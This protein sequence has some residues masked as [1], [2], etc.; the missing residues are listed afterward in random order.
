MKCR[1]AFVFIFLGI[2]LSLNNDINAYD[3]TDLIDSDS[4]CVVSESNTNQCL[5]ESNDYNQAMQYGQQ[6][7]DN[8]WFIV[9]NNKVVSANHAIALLDQTDCLTNVEYIQE[10]NDA[11]GY[12]NGCYGVDSA[13]IRT[14]S[15]ASHALIRLSGVDAWVP[16]N[17]VTIVPLALYNG[18]LSVYY[19]EDG[20]L[21]HAILSDQRNY[22]S[23]NEYKLDVAPDFFSEG[24]DY[25]SYDGHYFYDDIT[26]CLNDIANNT[27]SNSVNFNQPYY[28]FYQ[29]NNHLT[30]SNVSNDQLSAILQKL[31]SDEAF[32][33]FSD[34]NGDS[35]ADNIYGSLLGN[36]SN[37]FINAQDLNNVNALMM[38]ALS[39]NESGYGRS[40]LAYTRNNLFGHAAYD[41]AV[42]AN[43]SRYLS[44]YSSIA[45][46]AKNYI[47]DSYCDASS[48]TYHG[49]YFGNKNSG[50]NV[51]YA[52]D[53]YWGEKAASYYYQLDKQLNHNDKNSH[54][55]IVSTN[56]IWV[57]KDATYNNH[58]TQYKGNEHVFE[59]VSLL[60]NGYKVKLDHS[61]EIDGLV[62]NEGFITKED[63]AYIYQ[64]PNEIEAP[65]AITIDANGGSYQNG[66]KTL[67]YFS[68]NQP[69]LIP[70]YPGHQFIAYQQNEQGVYVAQY[71]ETLQLKM[72]HLPKLLY[73]LNETID[74]QDGLVELTYADGTKESVP[75]SIE[76]LSN[77]STK[78]SG[79]QSVT[80]SY[81]GQQCT[82][83]I[84]VSS[85]KD[86]QYQSIKETLN[87]TLEYG[88]AT[89]QQLL[90]FKSLFDQ[91]T[92]S[93]PRFSM[94]EYAALSAIFDPVLALNDITI[95]FSGEDLVSV[96][97]LGLA[98][99]LNHYSDNALF[100]NHFQINLTQAKAQLA[101]DNPFAQLGYALVKSYDLIISHNWESVK[102]LATPI[103]IQL[104]LENLNNHRYIVY[105]DDGESLVQ[106][107]TY[108]SASG[109]SFISNMIGKI[110][111]V[112]TNN[113]T[114]IDELDV[115]GYFTKDNQVND[116]FN[117]TDLILH[118]LIALITI[119][120]VLLW[121][122]LVM[123]IIKKGRKRAY[124]KNKTRTARVSR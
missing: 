71:K 57:Y 78:E 69:S 67:T 61:V 14:N 4:Y 22:L 50:M 9:K 18:N 79:T 103:L 12:T 68:Y 37:D 72:A 111:I 62:Y 41:H 115:S 27:S 25:Y 45:S 105:C 90:E 89:T 82:Y 24:N 65:Q 28:N 80:V 96:G 21:V 97:N 19:V 93:F 88:S 15:N 58:L 8:A 39:L 53:P 81:G 77:V 47:V 34:L 29:Y 91:R 30:L 42:E 113:E 87:A 33:Y 76:M 95:G 110:Y 66:E 56:D 100:A 107:P 46:H 55:F 5:F 20:E 108:Q 92:S 119:A 99:N 86:E 60:D 83:L 2:I 6:L 75:L 1:W 10:S 101:Q 23:R 106:L 70:Y 112:D 32:T 64:G 114:I 17:Q 16:I 7:S 51:S 63:V 102:S 85:Q 74:T 123:V 35:V 122:G 52:S 117:R 26:A 3:I 54:G 104:S 44:P 94:N 48:F 84:D 116:P 31:G 38:V 40:Y 121:I 124:R 59:L 73:E 109:L 120:V 49:C 118:S 98:L 11:S 13:Y 43:A 36:R